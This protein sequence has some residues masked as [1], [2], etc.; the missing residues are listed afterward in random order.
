[1]RLCTHL[2]VLE[3]AGSVVLK[4]RVQPVITLAVETSIVRLRGIGGKIV[5]TSLGCENDRRIVKGKVGQLG[6][7]RRIR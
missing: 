5:F 3:E 6:L 7:G 4:L 1:M 2:Y